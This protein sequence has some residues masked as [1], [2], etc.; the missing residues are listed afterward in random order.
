MRNILDK[1]CRE[2]QNT[3][4]IHN[5]LFS[6]IAL[7]MR[8]RK[9]WW[10]E[11]GQWRHNMANT[12]CMLDMHGNTHVCASTRPRA[13]ARTRAHTHKYV[14]FIAFQWQ[15]LF[16]ERAA[17]LRYMCI[18]CL[19][20]RCTDVQLCHVLRKCAHRPQAHLTIATFTA[21]LSTADLAAP[22]VTARQCHP[23]YGRTADLTAPSVTARQCHPLYGQHCRFGSTIGHCTTVP[24]TLRT[25]LRG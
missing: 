2:N 9:I 8:Y 23:L 24:S 13:R 21:G 1:S 17:V 5:N 25:A 7:F 19:D 11:R 15:Q 22:S 12:T 6:K 4:F 14:T 3:H 20:T 16:C 18:A 10:S